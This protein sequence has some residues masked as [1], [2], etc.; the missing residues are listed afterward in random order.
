MLLNEKLNKVV[1]VYNANVAVFGIYNA[2]LIVQN[3][4]QSTFFDVISTRS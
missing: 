1:D 2:I 3:G 4:K